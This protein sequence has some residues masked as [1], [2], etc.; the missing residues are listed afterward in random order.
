[1]SS[2]LNLEP[3][4]IPFTFNG[5]N[6]MLREASGK[7]AAEFRNAVIDRSV[8]GEDGK[9][10]SIK[11]MADVEP[12]LVAGCVFEV[13]EDP[14]TKAK[15]EVTVP[16]SRVEQWPSRLQARLFTRIREISE[17]GVEASERSLLGKALSVPGS[18]ITLG[19]LRDYCA[20]LTDEQYKPL[21]KW[22]AP[23]AEEQAGNVQSG[24]TVGSA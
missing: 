22:L 7:A 20:K 1:M 19:Q 3:V 21:H 18:P 13:V 8:I 10:K 2:D 6:Y 11:S 4:S 23:T 9:V 15:T 17:L 5:N 12:L 24:T 14:T 16:L